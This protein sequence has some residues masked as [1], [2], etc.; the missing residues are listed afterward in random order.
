MSRNTLKNLLAILAIMGKRK[1]DQNKIIV[2]GLPEGTDDEALEA[3]FSDIG[4]IYSAHMVGLD[5]SGKSRG[6]GFVT[7]ANNESC[8]AAVEKMHKVAGDQTN[9]QSFKVVLY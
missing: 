8:I 7:F 3:M 1:R 9:H 5:S 4:R 6:Y 2:I